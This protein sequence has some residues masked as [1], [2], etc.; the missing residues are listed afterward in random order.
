MSD[1]ERHR[2]RSGSRSQLIY[3]DSC[4]IDDFDSRDYSSSNTF[5][6]S[7][8]S[9]FGSDI[10]EICSDSSTK[11]GNLCHVFDVMIDRSQ[12]IIDIDFETTRKLVKICSRIHQCWRW[13]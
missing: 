13:E 8:T 1:I 6:P 3:G 2:Y 9:A 10:P 5:D 11:F 7:N 12:I 4:V